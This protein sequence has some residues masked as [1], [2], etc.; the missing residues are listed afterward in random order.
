MCITLAVHL[1][2][3]NVI[4]AIVALT[5]HKAHCIQENKYFCHFPW[6]YTIAINLSPNIPAYYIQLLLKLRM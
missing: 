4:S 1:I 6:P 5:K 3:V 2:T